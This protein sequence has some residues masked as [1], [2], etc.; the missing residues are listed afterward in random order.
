MRWSRNSGTLCP[1]T[2]PAARATT[3]PPRP[4]IIHLS[5]T[6][7]SGEESEEVSDDDGPIDEREEPDTDGIEDESAESG[8]DREPEVVGDY[9]QWAVVDEQ[10]LIFKAR[11]EAEDLD[12]FQSRDFASQVVLRA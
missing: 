5:D 2:A 12:D 7:D 6:P 4:F 3:T 11:A 9:E 8:S 10:E 1:N